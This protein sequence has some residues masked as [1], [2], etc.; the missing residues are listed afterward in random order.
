[1]GLFLSSP[2]ELHFIHGSAYTKIPDYLITIA[3]QH[4]LKSGAWCFVYFHYLCGSLYKIGELFY[5]LKIFIGNFHWDCIESL[6]SFGS[7]EI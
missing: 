7:R 5:F 1:M 3:L 4:S 2:L 6:D